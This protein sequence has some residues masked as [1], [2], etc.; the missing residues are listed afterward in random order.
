MLHCDK[1]KA[2]SVKVGPICSNTE[3]ALNNHHN[4]DDDEE[5]EEEENDDEDDEY[6]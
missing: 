4:D 6:R 1:V 2:A 3:L 5:E